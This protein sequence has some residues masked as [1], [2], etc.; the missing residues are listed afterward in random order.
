MGRA[1]TR[2]VLLAA[3]AVV[4]ALGVVAGVAE[5]GQAAPG[6][7][8]LVSIGTFVAPTYITAPPG[9]TARVFVV[10]K[11]GTVEVLHDGVVSKFLDIQSRVTQSGTEQGLLSIAFDPNYA[12]NGLLYADY[13]T[14]SPSGDLEIDEFHATGNAVDSAPRLVLLVPH[15][16]AQNHN[17]G[18]LQFG[19]DGDLYIG[20]GDGGDED[21]TQGNGQNPASLLAKILRIDP[22]QSGASPYTVPAD[23]PAPSGQHPG[24]AP[25]VYAMGLRNPWRF[26]FDAPTGR[27]VIAD[28]GQDMYEE[29]DDL[30]DAG[31]RG[32][33]FGWSC[34]EANH[35]GPTSMTP[36]C[37]AAGTTWTPPV[38]E[39]DHSGGRCSITGGVVVHDFYLPALAGRYV[40]GDYCS[41][42]LYSFAPPTTDGAA[43]TDNS[44][45]GL[46]VPQLSS[47]GVDGAG[48]VYAASLAGTVYRLFQSGVADAPPVP[49]FTVTPN[50]A[51]PGQ[52]VKVDASGSSDPDGHIVTYAWDLTGDGKTD[53]S[54]PTA[55]TTYAT[56]GTHSITLTVTDDGGV[57]ASKS[58]AL[59]VRAA[60][61]G[62]GGTVSPGGGSNGG[63]SGGGSSGTSSGAAHLAGTTVHVTT[64]HR[65]ASVLRSGLAVDV[66]SATSAHWAVSLIV[67]ARTAKRLHVHV[68]K[69][70]KLISIG[71]A[72]RPKLQ[73]GVQ[74][75][76]VKVKPSVRAAL[77]R[78]A[79]V[80]LRVRAVAFDSAHRSATTWRS[81]VF[82]R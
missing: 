72:L 54:G 22:H 14:K 31:A 33:N 44:A 2:R 82:H 71:S 30:S 40:Y 61:T 75:V 35:P 21:D 51:T 65:I 32:A 39:Y 79:T 12:T 70:V 29:V 11:R 77:G 42:D 64:T 23:N 9:D 49:S 46:N 38:L 57:S 68:A 17:G 76:V 16:A 27:L 63:S 59:V 6:A 60:G 48:H 41:G 25:E 24:W 69:G 4:A 8:Q 56:T 15:I 52:T 28:V 3:L 53:A 62:T 80:H 1:L 36:N 73:R 20:T 50:P 43:A 45:L 19:P 47:F 10:E 74:T 66:R 34:T 7:I 18:Q 26:S 67:D 55:S 5:R 37:L 78:L 13:T 58:V 81:L